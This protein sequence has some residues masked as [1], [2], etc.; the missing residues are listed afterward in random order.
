[1][2]LK[3]NLHALFSIFGLLLVSPVNAA[4]YQVEVIVFDQ[5]SPDFDGELWYENPGLPDRD[6]SIE[7]ITELANGDE[8]SIDIKAAEQHS[9]EILP[10]KPES[11][12]YLQ[13]DLNKLR[14]EGV[15]RVLKLSREYRPLMH[16]AWQQPGFTS[17]RAR[18]VHLQKFEEADELSTEEFLALEPDDLDTLVNELSPAEDFHQVLDLI[19]DGTIRLRSSKFLHID[20]DIAYFPVYLPNEG[21]LQGEDETLFVQQQ[22]DYVRLQESRKIRLNEIHYFDHPFFGVILRVSRLKLN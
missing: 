1:L 2:K 22:A 5:L 7:L 3:N 6:N 14:L 13:L 11:I 19:F 18:A 20:V 21:A 16:V 4:W 12:P 17:N 9:S 15:R 10:Y 8:Q